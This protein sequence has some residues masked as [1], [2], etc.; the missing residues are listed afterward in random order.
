MQAPWH[1]CSARPN[2]AGRVFGSPGHPPTCSSSPCLS[3]QAPH[4]PYKCQRHRLSEDQ[5]LVGKG[6]TTCA[7][8]LGRMQRRSLGSWRSSWRPRVSA[9]M[10]Q[11]LGLAAQ[12]ADAPCK[13]QRHRLNKGHFLVGKGCATRAIA[14]GRMQ[15]RSQGYWPGHCG[16][17]TSAD[18]RQQPLSCGSGGCAPSKC[19]RQHFKEGHFRVGKGC[20]TH[21]SAF[22][23]MQRRSQGFLPGLWDP[24]GSADMQ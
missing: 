8:A 14:F 2:G 15:C 6:C 4:A 18:M 21:A 11:Q 17:R 23:R 22:G 20:V 3:A 24:R 16:P 5:F 9:D 13:C 7:S 1:R 19:Q 12:V 10:Q